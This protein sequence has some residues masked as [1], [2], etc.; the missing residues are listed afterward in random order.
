MCPEEIFE[1]KKFQTKII[2]LH[3]FLNLSWWFSGFWRKMSQISPNSILP[4]QTNILPKKCFGENEF[5]LCGFSGEKSQTFGGEVS[6]RNFWG[7]KFCKK[8][9]SNPF[10][11]L[12]EK[13]SNFSP[14]IPSRAVMTAFY[15]STEW[16]LGKKVLDV[17]SSLFFSDTAQNFLDFM[18]RVF[19]RIFNYA[20]YSP[21]GS[22]W[23]KV[24]IEI[25]ASHSRFS[26]DNRCGFIAQNFSIGLSNLN[27]KC[28]DHPISEKNLLGYLPISLFLDC[29]Q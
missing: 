7:Y 23:E 25:E 9:N 16:F 17:Y 4:V 5:N 27:P 14:K 8:G 3:Q 1:G 28:L 10:L 2:F 19:C 13:V 15:V 12:R 6:R 11:T 20:F 21:K 18:R 22:F 24:L 29:E 26:S